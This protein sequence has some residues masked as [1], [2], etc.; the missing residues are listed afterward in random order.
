MEVSASSVDAPG[1]PPERLARLTVICHQLRS[2]ENLGALA[3][4]MAN[5]GVERLVLSEPVTHDFRGAEQLAVGALPV[6]RGLA[7]AP[8]LDE[9]L[10]G[11]VYVLGT[12]SRAQLKRFVS[13]TPE[14]GAARLAEHAARGPVA[15][16]LGGEKRGLSDDEL[17]RCQ[18]VVAIP[19]HGPQPSMNLSHAGAVLLYVTSRALAEADGGASTAGQEGEGLE[20]APLGIVRAL[21]ERLREVLLDCEFLN[22]QAP[23]HVLGE[24]TR[25]LVRGRLTRREAGHWLSA[26]EHVRRRLRRP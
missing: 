18:D 16:L 25:T 15:W 22:P 23:Q 7:V 12:T 24:L 10:A 21:E 1:R 4:V 13:L 26:F 2:A 5:F 3:R 8:T 17:A 14:A 11:Q 20:G 9:A 19:A 6:L